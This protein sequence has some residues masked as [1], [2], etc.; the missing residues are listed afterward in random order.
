[1]EKLLDEI[2]SFPFVRAGDLEIDRDKVL[3]R[4]IES[5]SDLINA[6]M[7]EYAK[8]RGKTRW[9]DKTPEYTEDIDIIWRLFP[10]C[11]IIHL[12]RDGRDV[13]LRQL[14]VALQNWF[15]KSL[16]LLSARWA[17]KTTICHKVGSVLGPDF[18]IEERFED[19]IQDP[20]PVLRR[21]CDFLGEPYSDQM[22]EYQRAAKTAVPQYPG[23]ENRKQ[24]DAVH[25][26]SFGE[27]DRKMVSTWKTKMSKS[28]RIIFEQ[29]AGYALDLFRY[30][31]E[32]LPATIASRL[33]NLYFNTVVR[34]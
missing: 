7:T 26:H 11:K 4:D 8:S 3:S 14:K 33:K 9:G 34:Y 15:S 10:G 22:L 27:L 16:P 12:V 32:H 21:I 6:M 25:K 23:A 20:Q 31:R 18:Y 19:L 29:N 30:E 17:Y 28:D 2:M 13:V 5:Y 24:L 1:M